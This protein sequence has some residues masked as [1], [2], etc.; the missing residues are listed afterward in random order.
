MRRIVRSLAGA[1]AAFLAT[2]ASA[3]AADRCTQDSL[4]VDGSPIALTLCAAAPDADHVDVSETY[5]RGSARI[6]RTLPIDV[7]RGAAVARAID[8]VPLDQLGSTKRLRVTVAYRD[9][10]ATLEHAL[11]LPGAVVLK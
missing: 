7:V 10:S 4:V 11:L 5:A 2:T 3:G 1:T 8:D 9:G 6:T